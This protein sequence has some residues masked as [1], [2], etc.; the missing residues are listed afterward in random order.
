MESIGSN[1]CPTLSDKPPIALFTI[2][3]QIFLAHGYAFNADLPSLPRIYAYQEQ[4][5]Y[6]L[7]VMVSS[8]KSHPPVLR[9]SGAACSNPRRSIHIYIQAALD[10]GETIQVLSPSVHDL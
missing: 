5:R 2:A 7:V 9:L 10:V 8:L 4:L 1:S 3:I 6:L